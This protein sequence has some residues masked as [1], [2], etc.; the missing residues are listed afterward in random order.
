MSRLPW[1]QP[2]TLCRN[3]LTFSYEGGFLLSGAD[4]LKG[5]GFSTELAYGSGLDDSECRD[6]SGEAFAAPCIAVMLQAF[7]LN[8]CA[9]WWPTEA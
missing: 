7:F 8:V 4:N 3:T 9:P 5:L 2:P 1:G 6:L